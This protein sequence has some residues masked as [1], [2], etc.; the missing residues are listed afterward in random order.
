MTD[1]EVEALVEATLDEFGGSYE[2]VEFCIRHYGWTTL[3]DVNA[4]SL[5]VQASALGMEN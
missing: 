2:V 4:E 1:T 5:S 3:A